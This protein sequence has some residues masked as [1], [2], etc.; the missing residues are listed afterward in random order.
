MVAGMS[1]PTAIP[2]DLSHELDLVV[3][4]RAAGTTAEMEAM[5]VRGVLEANGIDSVLV[6]ASQ[7]PTM[8]VLVKV[9]RARAEEALAAIREA[10]AAGP[11]AAEEAEQA[12]EE[13]AG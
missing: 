6:E 5:A 13:P 4:F 2:P 12:S 3:V 10:E 9:A 7:Y 8:P 11:E 1:E